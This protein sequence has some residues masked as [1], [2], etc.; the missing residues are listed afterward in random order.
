MVLDE[1][2]M[3]KIYHLQEV[4]VANLT[5]LIDVSILNTQ[6]LVCGLAVT[7]IDL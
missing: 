2:G 5:F 3:I 6:K 1:K 7:H 4:I